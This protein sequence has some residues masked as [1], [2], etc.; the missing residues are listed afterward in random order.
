MYFSQ[1]EERPTAAK[2]DYKE[3]GIQQLKHITSYPELKADKCQSELPWHATIEPCEEIKDQV[4]IKWNFKDVNCGI[5][6][7]TNTSLSFTEYFI[8]PDHSKI[9]FE[10]FKYNSTAC[11]EYYGD[12]LTYVISTDA[13]SPSAGN[14]TLYNSVDKDAVCSS[15]NNTCSFAATGNGTNGKKVYIHVLHD[16]KPAE[17]KSSEMFKL[18]ACTIANVVPEISFTEYNI[19]YD[20]NGTTPK[21]KFNKWKF[22]DADCQAAHGDKLKYAISNTTAKRTVVPYFDEFASC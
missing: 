16:G 18:K 7:V 1:T 21:I 14:Q 8:K 22:E 13:S 10:K 17:S 3:L 11:Q 20:L 2:N 6:N 19:P 15:T 5:A 4:D 12:K 9:E